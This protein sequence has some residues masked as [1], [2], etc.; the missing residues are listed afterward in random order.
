MLRLGVFAASNDAFYDS[1][2]AAAP[3]KVSGALQSCFSADH[4]YIFVHLHQ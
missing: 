2:Y 1:P 3:S 4:S